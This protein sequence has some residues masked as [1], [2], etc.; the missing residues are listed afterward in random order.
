MAAPAIRR[1][2]PSGAQPKPP[3]QSCGAFGGEGTGLSCRLAYP[4]AVGSWYRLR[5][6]KIS[7]S[8]AGVWWGA[9]VEDETTKV[10]SPLGQILVPANQSFMSNQAN[11]SE[12]FGAPVAAP[13]L[14]PQSQVVWS[15]PSADQVTPGKYSYTSTFSHGTKGAGTTGSVRGGIRINTPVLHNLLGVQIVQ[16][17]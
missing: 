13:K 6:W 8:S 9:W 5:V 16:G 2:S 14:V 1:S 3:G 4:I 10:D 7:A 12:Y 15:S 17:G 11:F